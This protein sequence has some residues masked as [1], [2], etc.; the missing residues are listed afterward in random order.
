ML[1]ASICDPSV[2][3]RRHAINQIARLISYGIFRF[4]DEIMI[5]MMLATLDADKD[6]RNDAKLY[7]VGGN[8]GEN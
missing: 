8:S 2:L 6:V 4:K 3:V 1:A 5:R 7:I